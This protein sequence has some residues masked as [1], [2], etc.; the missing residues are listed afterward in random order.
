MTRG[1]TWTADAIQE[2][3][4]VSYNPAT[5]NVSGIDQIRPGFV[6]RDEVAYVGTH[7]HAPD[8]DQVYIPT[9]LFVYAIDLPPA[10]QEVQLP[11]ND[12]VRIFAITVAHQRYHL[13]P[14][15][16]LYAANLAEP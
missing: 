5:G 2:D 9:Y 4:V 1:Q 10:L 14:A 3:L 8:G 6:K 11:S 15:T 13:W 7:R 16:R 12:K